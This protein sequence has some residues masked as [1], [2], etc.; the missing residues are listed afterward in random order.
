MIS[1]ADCIRELLG[2]D[3]VSHGWV[4]QCVQ[5]EYEPHFEWPEVLRELLSGDVE[6]GEAKLS[7][8]D[9]VEFI[10]WK[11]TIAERAS[12]A[13]ERVEGLQAPDREFAYWLA[14]RKNV[15]RFEA[16]E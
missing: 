6:I 4:V 14:L 10:A 2:Q 15:D 7:T 9:H 1:V 8:P 12:R 5:Q 11:G 3:I 13:V 16:G